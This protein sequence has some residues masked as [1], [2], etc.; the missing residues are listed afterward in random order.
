[1]PVQSG[2]ALCG[3]LRAVFEPVSARKAVWMFQFPFILGL[4]LMLPIAANSQ[5]AGM[6]EAEARTIHDRL[7]TIDTH[8]D[9]G[10]GYATAAL[11]PGAMTR[12]QVDL[13][14][15]RIGGLD[16]GFFIVYTAQGALDA[17]GYA[18]ARLAAE[19]KFRGIERMLR[20]YPDQIAHARSAD[21]VEQIA[22][23]GRLVAL[24]G[25]E[26]AYPL[27]E[28]V[29]DVPMWAVRGVRYLSITHFGNNQFGDSS[30]PNKSRGDPDDDEGLTEL[31]RELIEALNDAGIMVDISHV[32][33]RTG[34][35]A[36]RLSRTP[37]IASHS[38]ARSVYDNPRNL[39][40]EQL[41][42]IAADDGVAQMV[43]YRSY[44]GEVD[45]AATRALG[46]LRDRLGLTSGSGFR[47]ATPATL[48]EYVRE[49]ADIR[50]QHPDVTLSAFADHVDHAVKVA[51]IDHV[52]L[53][54]DF[55]G[56]G[57]V[58]GW[59]SADETFNVTRELL[60]RGYTED[61]LAKLWGQNVLRVL[62][63]AEA[64][65]R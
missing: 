14:G 33:K 63:A 7:L 30:N 55:D 26:N 9:I 38:G 4:A 1:M 48:D 8:I 60:K 20:A 17:E 22:A 56:G 23:S 28:G 29:A 16:A 61:D 15:M 6:S 19:D 18:A 64:A 36:M 12:A 50:A 43:A 25:M 44:L 2:N 24:M 3:V 51:G 42:A 52:G 59:D 11:D 39:D 31:G 54:G 34:L 58:Q 62:R 27:G 21:E 5:T 32:G 45:P 65:A 47:T 40:D 13:P 10:P 46:E 53:S 35:E 41:L 57:G 49:R 37:V